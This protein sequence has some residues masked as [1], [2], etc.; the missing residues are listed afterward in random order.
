VIQDRPPAD[1][2]QGLGRVVGRPAC[3]APSPTP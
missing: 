1:R 3:R 2:Q